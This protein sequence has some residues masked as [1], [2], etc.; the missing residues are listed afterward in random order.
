MKK[1][2]GLILLMLFSVFIISACDTKEEVANNYVSVEINPAVELIIDKDGKILAANG[3]NDDGKTLIINISFEGKSLEEAL[4]II[5]TEAKESGY[6]LTA[7][8]NSE[9]VSREINVSI[10]SE[11][12]E[13]AEKINESVSYTVN[14]YIEEYDLS[15][16][17]KKLDAKGREYFE[18][19]VKKYN[20]MITDE[21]LKALSYK[22]LLEMVELATIEKAQI[23][24]IA[25]EEY[26]LKVKEREFKFAYKE[27][28]AKEL[29]SVLALSYKTAL[30][31]LKSASDAL[32]KLEY[33]LYVSEDSQYLK[34]LNE[35][36]S[37]K[38]EIIK[39][40]AELA[41][42]EE[43]AEI[44]AQI[45]VKEEL[46][47]Q[48]KA[49]IESVMNLAK[50]TIQTAREAL[51][52]AYTALESIEQTITE[53][54]FNE[55]LT[56]VEN[57]INNQKDGLFKSFEEKYASDILKIKTSV[58]NRKSELEKTE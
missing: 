31:A 11:N 3:T 44:T 20:P 49:N 38:D 7:T 39:L 32:D 46:L 40:K 21:E 56:N 34:L 14:K 10:D 30:N 12:K 2:F 27:A 35:L 28:I 47:D 29:N 52:K 45:K 51:N 16:T 22:E 53:I 43:T 18:A 24:S 37:H 54:D 25:L 8:Y 17:Y 5:L 19:I 55:V 1:I 33:N 57:D 50:Q 6:L 42:N 23:A 41:I 15:A 9:F 13:I 36:N 4:N 26:Y 48:I 58:E